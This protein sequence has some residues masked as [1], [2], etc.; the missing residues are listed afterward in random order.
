MKQEQM[1]NLSFLSLMIGFLVALTSCNGESQ[2]RRTGDTQIDI[3]LHGGAE[4][5]LILEKLDVGERVMIDT[6]ELDDEGKGS[7][8]VNVN[9]VSLLSVRKINEQGEII[10]IGDKGVEIE[11]VAEDSALANSFRLAG[12]AE[13]EALDNFVVLEREYQFLKDSLNRIY[14]ALQKKNQHFVVEEEF[15]KI[16]KDRML[17]REERV[18]AF[19]DAHE[20]QFVNLLAVRSLDFKRFPEYYKKV[21]EDL[22]EGFSQ[23]EHVKVF[24][25]DVNRVMA[26]AV[27]G[28]APDFTLPMVSGKTGSLQDYKGKVLLL[29]FWATWCRPCIAEIPNLKA[30]HEQFKAENFEILSICVDRNDFKPNWQKI[31]ENYEM[32]WP[33]FFDGTGVAAQEYA[34]EYFPT[35]FLLNEKGE[36]IAKNIRGEE[37]TS[38]LRALFQ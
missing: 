35:I 2:S 1:K 5:L 21:K 18:K 14:L 8:F 17:E 22:E 9:S 12:S 25:R 33:Q 27:G 4:R 38:R 26:S 3:T 16:Y 34:I 32:D 11:I 13:N 31:I 23:S 30:V 29:D 36:I 6:L 10:F 28:L 7:F 20:G 19:I 15:N 37:I 24:V